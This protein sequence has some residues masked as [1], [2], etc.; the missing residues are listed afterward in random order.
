MSDEIRTGVYRGL[1]HADQLVTTIEDVS[2]IYA[3]GFCSVGRRMI[4]RVLAQI[5]RATE[6]CDMSQGF[7]V[8]NRFCG[9]T[10][11]GFTLLALN[12]LASDYAKRSKIQ[13]GIYP[14]LRLSAGTVEPYNSMPTFNSSMEQSEQSI[15]TDNESLYD[16]CGTR[17]D[18]PRPTCTDVNRIMA[19]IF[20]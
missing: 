16:I 6:A 7:F 15:L 9:G 19:V 8:I 14:G 12:H 5:R 11:S 20:S 2:N 10:G 4:N 18:V 13:V 17:L 1:F 3:R